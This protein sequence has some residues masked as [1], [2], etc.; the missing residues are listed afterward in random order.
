MCEKEK[1]M[2]KEVEILKRYFK[3]SC[4]GFAFSL[5]RGFAWERNEVIIILVDGID[6]I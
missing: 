2:M 5:R 1:T 6:Y 4:K 3:N